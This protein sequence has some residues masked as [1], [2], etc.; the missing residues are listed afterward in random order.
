MF[1]ALDFFAGSGLV[2][3]GLQ[4]EFETIWANDNC[5]KKRAVYEVNHPEDTF[6]PSDIEEV[7][8]T[9]LPTADLAWA[10]FP[11]QD[12][13]LA[14]NLNGINSG[15]RS[16]VFWQWIRVL[17]DMHR[18]KKL[19]PIV[20]AENVV[21]FVV[22]HE[23]RHFRRAY[24]ALRQLGYRVGAVVIDAELF[25]PQSRPRAFVIAVNHR[26]DVTGLTQAVPSQPFHPSGL[27]R[28]ALTAP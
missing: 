25:V 10:S 23:G 18:A 1:Q 5:P 24:Q 14:G 19:P 11:C 13:S 2:R 7:S 8:G 9:G 17:T 28:T 26:V 4:P 27:V 22:A 21:G 20:V 15:T 16:G 12:L 3:L 6:C